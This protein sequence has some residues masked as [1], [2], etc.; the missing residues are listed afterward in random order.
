MFRILSTAAAA[1]VA[2]LYYGT[3]ILVVAGKRGA[4]E[5]RVAI[6]KAWALT[7]LRGA[8][9]RVEVE[10][11]RFFKE[12]RARV[13]VA[14]HASLFDIL[15]FA[16][17]VP[18]PYAWVMKKELSRIVF[19][20]RAVQAAG[21][22]FVDRSNTESSISSLALVGDRMRLERLTV[23][24]FPEG[25][26][27]RTGKLGPFKRGAVMLGI[28]AGADLVPAAIRG[29]FAVKPKGLLRIRPGTIRVRLGEPIPLA[30][31]STRERAWLTKLARTR[32]EGLLQEMEES[33]ESR[34]RKGNNSAFQ[35]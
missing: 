4:A 35:A 30:G 6:Q 9:V 3:R 23:I 33:E 31:R 2:T 5:E 15:A 12:R 25:T 1:V 27:T 18:V 28:R 26:R 17:V 24:M 34:V 29:S 13:V 14:N 7:A 21:H 8:G 11:A 32:V 20:G 16:A 19:F 22:F 10:N